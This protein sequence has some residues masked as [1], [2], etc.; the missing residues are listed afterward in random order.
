MGKLFTFAER[1]GIQTRICC[2]EIIGTETVTFSKN[3]KKLVF[4]TWQIKNY[5]E[6]VIGLLKRYFNLWV[7]QKNVTV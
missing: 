4:D 1:N 2:L 5:P 7:G 3:G 6:T